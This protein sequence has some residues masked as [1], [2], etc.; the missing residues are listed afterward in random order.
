MNIRITLGKISTR[1]LNIKGDVY[2]PF[3]F[4]TGRT[5]HLTEGNPSAEVDI[6][7]LNSQVLW[8][9]YVSNRKGIIV[10]EGIQAVKNKL[11]EDDYFSSILKKF[12]GITDEARQEPIKNAENKEPEAVSD[13]GLAE[14]VVNKKATDAV[15]TIGAHVLT[16][17]DELQ[18]GIS[19]IPLLKSIIEKENSREGGPRKTVLNAC[20]KRIEA[21]EN[22]SGFMF[23][24][25]EII[26]IPKEENIIVE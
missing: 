24:E 3:W 21:I 23:G 20:E 10:V 16:D 18:Y 15:D 14:E 9:V 19:N 22:S 25:E 8:E 11:I 1:G 4:S 12:E 2:H 13:N 7:N 5:I 26:D 6:D 17:N